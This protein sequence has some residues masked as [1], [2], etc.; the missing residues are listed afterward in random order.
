ML[1]T[2]RPQAGSGW[3]F[4]NSL[5][6]ALD[7]DILADRVIKPALK[8]N[9]LQWKGWHAY[10]R[11]LATNLHE[12]G[13]PD[14]VIQAIL[15]HEEVKTTH[16]ELNQDGG[17]RGDRGDE[18]VGRENCLCS[19]CAAGFDQLIRKLLKNM[20]PMIGLEPMTCRLRKDLTLRMLL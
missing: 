16:E 4:A 3:M 15:H 9:G 10:R 20:E 6:G 11:G 7:L 12:L 5:G 17:E 19:R 18:A 8:A 2:I 1:D 13:I 14:K